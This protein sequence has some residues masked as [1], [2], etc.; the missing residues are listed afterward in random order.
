[1]NFN[2]NFSESDYSEGRK[3]RSFLFRAESYLDGENT[4]NEYGVLMAYSYSDA[5]AQLEKFYGEELLCLELDM[6]EE[7]PFYFNK[8]LYDRFKK[9][10]NPTT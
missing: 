4:I 9:E 7:G 8:E 5:A 6:L 1:M 10:V 3:M 2:T